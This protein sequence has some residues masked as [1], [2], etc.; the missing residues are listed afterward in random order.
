ML[1]P[2]TGLRLEQLSLSGCRTLRDLAPLRGMPLQT[3]NLSRTAVADLEPLVESPLRELNLEGCAN[4]GDL[5]PL[6]KIATLESLLLPMQSKDIEFLRS[7]PSLQ[8]IDTVWGTATGV[9]K[10]AAVFWKEYDAK[11]ATAPK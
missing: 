4:L 9:V 10:P 5:K 7:L 2:L 11:K 3:L 6:M 8:R 1:T